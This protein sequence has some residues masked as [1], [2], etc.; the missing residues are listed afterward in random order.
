MAFVVA[1]PCVKCKFTDC[2]SVCPVDCFREG[3]NMLVIDPAECIDCGACVPACPTAAIFLDE[4]V[5]G[6]WSEYVKLNKDLAAKWP[7]ISKQ[8]APLPEADEFKAVKDKRAFLK[9]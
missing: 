8:K 7:A 9:M 3:E 4:D 6:E 5:P 1:E 2:V